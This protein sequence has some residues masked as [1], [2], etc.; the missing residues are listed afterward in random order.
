[1]TES[2]FLQRVRSSPN[3]IG[4]S[5]VR[6]LEVQPTKRTCAHRCELIGGSNANLVKPYLAC[7]ES[8]PEATS[9]FAQTRRAPD[10]M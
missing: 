4:Q 5:V 6:L 2:A 1:M 10:S 9:G 7:C 3:R 8:H